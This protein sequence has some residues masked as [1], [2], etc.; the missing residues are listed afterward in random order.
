MR[1]AATGNAAFRRE[2]F[3]GDG[4]FNGHAA[5]HEVAVS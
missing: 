4:I 2:A 1:N 3:Y 5:T